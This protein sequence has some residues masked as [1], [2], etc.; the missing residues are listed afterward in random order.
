MFGHGPGVFDAIF[1][2]QRL[3]R[4]LLAGQVDHPLGNIYPDHLG[5]TGVTQQSR[6]MPFTT[7][8]I[9]H[10]F[11]LDIADQLQE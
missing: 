6:E 4:L 9:E 7:G 10:S 3:T 8:E 11:A 2:T 1:D 5:G